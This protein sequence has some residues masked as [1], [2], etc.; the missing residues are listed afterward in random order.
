MKN[1]YW[2]ENVGQ[3]WT[4][5]MFFNWPVCPVAKAYRSPR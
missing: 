5:R 2:Y 1:M 3:W 4:L